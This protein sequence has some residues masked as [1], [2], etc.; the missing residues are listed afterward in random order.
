M[1]RIVS[2]DFHYVLRT[3]LEMGDVCSHSF[4]A[5]IQFTYQNE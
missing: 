2:S 1:H 3:S 4:L 5:I